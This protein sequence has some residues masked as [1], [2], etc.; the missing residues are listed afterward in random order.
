MENTVFFRAEK[1]ME[2]WYLLNTEKFL[3]W[4]LQRWEIRPYFEPKSWWRDDIYWL[5]KSS[6]FQHFGYGK[7]VFSKPKS[8]WKEDIYWLRKSSSFQHFG[9]EKYVFS[10]PKNWWKEDIYWLLKSSCFELFG[11]G[12]CPSHKNK[13]RFNRDKPSKLISKLVRFNQV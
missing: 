8:W 11:D 5:L 2:R 3:F 1:L 6:S 4:T 10:E 13:P 7:Y 9:Y 12:K